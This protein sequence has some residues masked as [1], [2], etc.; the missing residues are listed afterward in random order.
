V[1]DS[2][3]ARDSDGTVSIPLREADAGVRL[4]RFLASRI[5]LSRSDA[6]RLLADGLVAL[7]GRIRGYSDKGLSLPATGIVR[8]LDARSRGEL[9]VKDASGGPDEPGA[10]VLAEPVRLAEGPGWLAVDKPAGWPV[11]PL[12]EDETG[13]VLNAVAAM[14]PE[15]RGVGDEGGLRSGVVHRL[16]TDTSGALLFATTDASWTR[17]R[18]AFREHRVEKVYRALVVGRPPAHLAP[19]S[20]E[21]GPETEVMLAVARHRPARVRVV[22]EDWRRRRPGHPARQRLRVVEP[23]LGASLIE[24]QIATGFLH[25]IRVTLAYQ[26]HPVLGDGLYGDERALALGAGRQML[27][28]ARVRFEE[29]VAESPDPEDFRALLDTLRSTTG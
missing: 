22:D 4:D 27:H 24:V 23:L 26:G 29:I 14:H 11:H 15:I 7:D 16:D 9:S 19:E 13:T 5:G 21:W 20:G 18:D 1:A 3:I 12:R 28:A 6:R 2:P 10:S 8:V 25:Q 17:L